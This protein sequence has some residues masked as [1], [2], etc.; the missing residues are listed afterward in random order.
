VTPALKVTLEGSN[1]TKEDAKTYLQFSNLP[2][3]FVGGDRRVS[4]GIRFKFG[5]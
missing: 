1:L 3:R 4:A 2:F 5:M